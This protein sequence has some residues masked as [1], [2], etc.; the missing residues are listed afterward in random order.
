MYGLTNTSLNSLALAPR[1][2][3]DEL[4]RKKIGG[5]NEGWERIRENNYGMHLRIM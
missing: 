1:G 2:G 4:K 5:K 3:E